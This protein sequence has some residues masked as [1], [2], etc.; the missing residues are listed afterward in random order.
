MTAVNMGQ[1]AAARWIPCLRNT[2][3]EGKQL[4]KDSAV[5]NVVDTAKIYHRSILHRSSTQYVGSAHQFRFRDASAL[6]QGSLSLLVFD[7]CL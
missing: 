3:F 2:K 4:S 7:P 6:G 1:Q 5:Y